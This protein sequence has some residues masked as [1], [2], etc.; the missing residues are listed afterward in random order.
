MHT[1]TVLYVVQPVI[2]QQASE[3]KAKLFDSTVVLES[4][5]MRVQH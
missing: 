1:I 5:Q 4:F 2:H 3:K